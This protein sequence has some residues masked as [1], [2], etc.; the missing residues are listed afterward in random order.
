MK[1]IVLLLIIAVIAVS[2]CSSKK[3]YYVSNSTGKLIN[4]TLIN[5]TLKILRVQKI[6]AKSTIYLDF[7]IKNSFEKGLS[8]KLRLAG[9]AVKELDNKQVLNDTDIKLSYTVDYIDKQKHTDIIRLYL[10]INEDIYT[11]GYAYNIENGFKELS[12][13][14]VNNVGQ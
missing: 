12:L 1:R 11:K 3:Y 8:E 14:S 2:G 9:Y 7:K 10:T 4:D 13:W 5:D 6:T